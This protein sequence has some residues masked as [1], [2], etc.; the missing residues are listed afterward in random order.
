M[1]G[2]FCRV[3]DWPDRQ[4]GRTEKLNKFLLRNVVDL[5]CLEV[6]AKK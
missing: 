5:A 2:A 6:R 4:C 3:G 1:E